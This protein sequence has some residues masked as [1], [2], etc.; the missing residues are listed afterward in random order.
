[1]PPTPQ[2]STSPSRWAPTNQ[3]SHTPED[4]PQSRK[5]HTLPKKWYQGIGVRYLGTTTQ[6]TKRAYKQLGA[7]LHPH[8]KA[9]HK[10]KA[11]GPFK[12]IGRALDGLLDTGPR[13]WHNVDIQRQAPTTG[14]RLVQ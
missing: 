10:K 2:P 7:K 14:G 5:C 13:R 11:E 8:K 3:R 1:M 6:E 4:R 12:H 9:H